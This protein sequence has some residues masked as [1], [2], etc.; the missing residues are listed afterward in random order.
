MGEGEL[1]LAVRGGDI[2]ALAQAAGPIAAANAPLAEYHQGR[3]MALAT[4]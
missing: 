3:R 1:Y 2:E 4:E